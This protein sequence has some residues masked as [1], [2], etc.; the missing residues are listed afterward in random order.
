MVNR[1]SD[2]TAR[3]PGA[4]LYLVATPIGAARDITLHAL[5]IL[6]GADV[7]AAEDTR[8]LRRLMEIH[9]IALGGRPLVAY[10]DHS[11]EK[12]R[13]R[14]LQAMAEGKSVAYAPEAGTAMVS[15][16]GFDLAREARAAGHAV[17]SA[18]GASAA[19]TAL[20]LS[21]LPTDRF[22][23]AGFLPATGSK[24][25]TALG[26]LAA[27]PATLVF[28]ESPHR[29]AEALA[30]AAAV[31]G[32]TRPAAIC[33]EL[34]KKF[35]EVL[36]G[37]LDELAAV[38]AERGLKGEIVFLVARGDSPNIREIDVDSAL[39]VALRTDSVRDA[40]DR[41]ARETGLKRRDVYQR[42]LQLSKE[43]GS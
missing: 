16:P 33:R 15:D 17:H 43:A 18:P 31:L 40:A 41:V 29:I 37:T 32:G 23:F 10:H 11:G 24:R 22:L 26:E 3:L 12:V 7:L 5:D 36:T 35:E 9:G 28:Y 1:S 39:A 19:I 34:T 25:K 21:G 30:D 42:A 20:T 4:G 14:L 2:E 38:A 13:A 27:V 6:A 8:S